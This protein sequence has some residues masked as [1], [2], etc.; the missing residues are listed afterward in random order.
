MRAVSRQLGPQLALGGLLVLLAHFV[1]VPSLARAS[2][3]E[4]VILGTHDADH[5]QSF[6]TGVGRTHLPRSTSGGAHNQ[7]GHGKPCSG[8]MCSRGS[9]PLPLTPLVPPPTSGEQWAHGSQVPLLSD[10]RSDA[11]SLEVNSPRSFRH[12]RDIYH[13]PR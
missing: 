11:H 3:G 2:C 5:A 4:Y 13:P 8:P 10:I 7:T 12:V 1:C 9:S 6:L